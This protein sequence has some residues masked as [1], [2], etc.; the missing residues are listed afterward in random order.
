MEW[1]LAAGWKRGWLNEHKAVDASTLRE[2]LQAIGRSCS[3]AEQS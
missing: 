2:G 3:E 1:A